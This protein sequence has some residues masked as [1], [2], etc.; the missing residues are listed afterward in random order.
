[1]SYLCQKC[2]KMGDPEVILERTLPEEY[3]NV[4]SV[5]WR[6]SLKNVEVRD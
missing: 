1:M 4:N 5:N 2:K 6:G 3:P